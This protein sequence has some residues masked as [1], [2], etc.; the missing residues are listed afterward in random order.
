MS[1]LA[2]TTEISDL[3]QKLRETKDWRSVAEQTRAILKRHPNDARAMRLLSECLLTGG[4]YKEL[5]DLLEPFVRKGLTDTT[6]LFR[7]AAARSSLGDSRGAAHFYKRV[8]DLQPEYVEAWLNLGVSLKTSGRAK[9][10]VAAYRKAIELRPEMPEAHNNLGLALQQLGDQEAAMAALRRAIELRPNY[11]RAYANLSQSLLKLDRIPEAEEMCRKA[12]EMDPTMVDGHLNLGLVLMAQNRQEETAEIFRAV[13]RLQPDDAK[14]LSNLGVAEKEVGNIEQAF[15]LQRS[16]NAVDLDEPTPLWNEAHVRMLAGDFAVGWERYEA[17]WG[18][19]DFKTSI[20]PWTVPA[21]QGEPIGNRALLLHVE[22]GVG[23][24]AQFCRYIPQICADNPGAEVI[25]EVQKSMQK[26]LQHSFRK[27]HRLTILHHNEIAGQNLPPFDLHLPMAS[28]PRVCGT[29][30]DAVPEAAGYFEAPKPRSY[31]Q[32]GDKLVVGISWKS[33]GSTGRKRSLT[34][35]RMASIVAKPGVRLVDLQYGDTREERQQLLE[36]QGVAIHH[37]DDVDAK[38][39]L[40]DFADQVVGCDLVVSIDNTTVHIA[41]AL[42]VPCWVVLPWLPDWRWMLRREDTPWYDSLKLYRP[43]EL[44]AW[45]PMLHRLEQDYDA[46]LA[47]DT[48]RLKPKRWEG[49]PSLVP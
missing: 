46:V 28:L 2:P 4:Q 11:P 44:N 35:E 49:P 1:E 26:L 32:P 23:D 42:G 16:A 6:L 13:A 47:G 29:R 22:Q 27:I 17:R 19:G 20:R 3:I 37:D 38:A 24:T 40:A 7:Y 12:I 30:F 25:V 21:W 15:D 41:G 31:R 9:D 10:A 18:T 33:V 8:T 36:Q 43:P 48:A 45:E 5:T 34:L 39:S 14:S